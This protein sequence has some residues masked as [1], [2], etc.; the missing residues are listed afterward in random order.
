MANKVGFTS[1][2]ALAT[3]CGTL[4]VSSATAG[5]NFATKCNA[6]FNGNVQGLAVESRSFRSA[7][8]CLQAQN[9]RERLNRYG[10]AGLENCQRTQTNF[11]LASIPSDG[12][13]GEPP[14]GGP[15]PGGPP[16]GGPP[17]GGPPGSVTE[18]G[19]NGW[20]NGGE[21][22]TNNGSFNGKGVSQGGPGLGK[23]TQTASKSKDSPAGKHEGR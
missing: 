19:N 20:G 17:P 6:Y 3:I 23:G 12:T 1:A 4:G 21:D 18:K 15:P 13:V 16:P 14:P 7:C 10:A 8:I 2:L 22:G 11:N 5:S 9:R